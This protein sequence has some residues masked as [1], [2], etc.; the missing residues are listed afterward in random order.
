MNTTVLYA[1]LV[2]VG[3]GTAISIVLFF[4]AIFGPPAWLNNLDNLKDISSISGLVSLIPVLSVIY[5]LGIII[6]NIGNILFEYFLKLFRSVKF[7]EKLR[8]EDFNTIKTEL[9]TYDKNIEDLKDLIEDF[10]FRRS[11]IRICRGWFINSF[12]IAAALFSCYQNNRIDE[13]TAKFFI[14]LALLLMVLTIVSWCETTKTEIKL[15]NEY[16]KHKETLTKPSSA[17][18]VNSP[19]PT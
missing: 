11:K 15:L 2:V 4:F 12:L 7:I 13:L 6:S 3:S 9:Y 17:A 18:E 16:K 10:E 8:L 14:I 1:E 19:L 5:L